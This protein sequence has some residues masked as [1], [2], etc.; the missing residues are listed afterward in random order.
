MMEIGGSRP[1]QSRS[2]GCDL[3]LLLLKTY[4]FDLD[5]RVTTSPSFL[6]GRWWATPVL[7]LALARAYAMAVEEAVICLVPTALCLQAFNAGQSFSPQS[8]CAGLLLSPPRPVQAVDLP[9]AKLTMSLTRGPGPL[10]ALAIKPPHCFPWLLFHHSPITL[11]SVELKPPRPPWPPL[12]P[13]ELLGGSVLPWLFLS[14]SLLQSKPLPSVTKSPNLIGWDIFRVG[15]AWSF[16]LCLEQRSF[17]IF[18]NS[19]HRH[20]RPPQ[21]RGT[22]R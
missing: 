11:D 17:P 10:F 13:L 20:P 5:L 19:G 16:E 2:N 7:L 21:H 18:S 4:R 14:V 15:L 12:M 3:L 1:P 6:I 8:R 9:W 22:S